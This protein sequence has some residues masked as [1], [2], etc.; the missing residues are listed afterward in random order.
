[1]D[2]LSVTNISI[3]VLAI[4]A[5]YRLLVQP[6][7]VSPL[8]KIPSAHY[9]AHISPFWIYYVRYSNIENKVLYE[10]HNKKG[11]I[12]RLAPNE[13]SINCY[14][15]GLKTVYTGGFE[16]TKF[17]FRRFANYN[18]TT[19]LFSIIDRI[20]H[21]RRK[22]MLTNVYAK[23]YVLASPTTQATTKIIIYDRLLPLIHSS[24][25][26][27]K[28]MEM[29]SLNY[30]YSIDSFT[31][32]QYGQSLA[33]NFIN[34]I[35]KR[36]WFLDNYFAPRPYMFWYVEV[37]N[38]SLWM[39]KFGIQL[40]PK[41]TREAAQSLEDWSLDICDRA[42]EL[43]SQDAPPAAADMPVVFAQQLAAMQ[44]QDL[45]PTARCNDPDSLSISQPYP[46][47]LEIASD[48]HCHSAA[49]LETSGDTLTYVYY[50]L[51]RRQ[52]LQKRLREELHTLPN[53]LIYPLLEGKEV[54]LP[55]FKVFDSL[56][57]LDA[58]LQETLR[59]WPAVPGGQPRVTPFPPCSLAGYDNIPPGVRVQASAYSLHRNPEIFKDPEDWKPERW[60]EA[61]PEQLTQMRRWFWAW[62]SGGRMCIGSNVAI[63]TMKFAIGSI[64]TN[65]SSTIVDAEGIELAEG[66][67]AG[68]KGNKL[69]LQYRYI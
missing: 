8:S 35:R 56:P 46:H 68:P 10:L 43:L 60:L 42:E 22:R 7:F 27:E 58:V 18:G 63:H 33:S 48:M 9:S 5:T 30:A 1:M 66:Y 13:L 54:E 61:T 16:K 34:D 51:S 20:S 3:I 50:E 21:S 39:A 25:E 37:P 31:A 15:Q 40:V 17:Y 19:N 41:W 57:I 69:L 62:G 29:L 6:L 45:G 26:E 49:A 2:S 4:F 32:Y 47:R 59:L 14:E 55:D 11:P 38:F 64:Y 44:K 24:T 52:D 65:Y 28:P 53:P 12:L 67:T 36:T 23:S